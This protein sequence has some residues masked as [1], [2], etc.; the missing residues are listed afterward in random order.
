MSMISNF[1]GFS[2]GYSS[3]G[4]TPYSFGVQS[5]RATTADSIDPNTG[6]IEKNGKVEKATAKGECTT[7]KNRKYVDGSDEM[8]SF[9]SPSK[10]SPE[11]AY[12]KVSAHEQEHVSNAYKKAR[13]G[14]GQVI[15]ASV[16]IKR[17]I[18]PECG[19]SYVAGGLTNTTIK[20]QKE[21][22]YSQNQKQADYASLAGSRVDAAI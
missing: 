17:A 15:N 9:K 2:Y 11:S 1:S 7:C 19:R 4:Y 10:I 21:S 18:C 5:P 20:Y 12:A 8:V 3:Y 16:T 14:N 6:E 13:E 22:P